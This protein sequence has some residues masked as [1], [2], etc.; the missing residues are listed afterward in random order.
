MKAEVF[1]EAHHGVTATRLIWPSGATSRILVSVV[2][3]L[4]VV[5]VTMLKF[6]AGPAR[7]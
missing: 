2:A 1:M 6:L 4:H 7:T 3:N 5:A